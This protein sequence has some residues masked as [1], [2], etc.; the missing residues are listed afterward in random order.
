MAQ[1]RGSTPHTSL[2]TL[3]AVVLI[4]AVLYAAQEVLIPIAFSILLSFLLAPLVIRLQRL[5]LG[6]IPSVLIVTVL[7][8]AVIGFVGWIV[9][10]Q[11]IELATNLPQY[12]DNIRSKVQSLKLPRTG[13]LGRATEGIK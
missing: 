10:G 7:S 2:M 8:F 6:R 13:V 3:L 12:K 11:V 4:V 5:R 9:T 1:P